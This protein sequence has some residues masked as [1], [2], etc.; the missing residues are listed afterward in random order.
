MR[1]QRSLRRDCRPTRGNHI[2]KGREKRIAFNPINE[3]ILGGDRATH[4]LMM[5]GQHPR[6]SI[7]QLSRQPSRTLNIGK[8]QGNRALRRTPTGLHDASLTAPESAEII[9]KRRSRADRR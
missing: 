5:V 3:A 8:Q 6:P 1:P 4:Q 7:A 2:I 9:E